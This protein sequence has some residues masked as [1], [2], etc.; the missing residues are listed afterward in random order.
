MRWKQLEA[1]LWFLRMYQKLYK[2]ESIISFA[3]QVDNLC[4]TMEISRLISYQQN[5][6]LLKELVDKLPAQMRLNWAL[7]KS[8][9]ENV[10]ISTFSSWITEIAEA[11]SEVVH[12][13]AVE[14]KKP[15][16]KNENKNHSK[17]KYEYMNTHI[18]ESMSKL[19]SSSTNEKH[20]ILR[21]NVAFAM[22]N[23]CW[24]SSA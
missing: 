18:H 19:Q 9:F 16:S 23:V 17:R 11:A 21:K 5:P 3:L 4:A 6:S 15:E 12:F 1:D 2:L 7:Y 24:S 10:T 22:V 14:L 8:N 13:Q 20:R